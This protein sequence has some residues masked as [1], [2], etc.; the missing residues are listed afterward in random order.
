MKKIF[1]QFVRFFALFRTTHITCQHGTHVGTIWIQMNGRVWNMKTACRFM[2]LFTSENFL[3]FFLKFSTSSRIF[4][5]Q[6]FIVLP[7]Q[8]T[9]QKV[10]HPLLKTDLFED[11]FQFTVK[12][13]RYWLPQPRRRTFFIFVTAKNMYSFPSKNLK[14]TPRK[15]WNEKEVRGAIVALRI[16]E[17]TVRPAY[18]SKNS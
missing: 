10:F 11:H 15:Y 18:V 5:V 12:K 9:G 13:K 6:W 17:N 8:Y 1:S 3:I 7:V 2:I 16:F 14:K 4:A